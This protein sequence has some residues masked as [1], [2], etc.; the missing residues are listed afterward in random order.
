MS[1][2]RKKLPGIKIGLVFIL[3]LVIQLVLPFS[4]LIPSISD[5]VQGLLSISIS[6]SVVNYHTIQIKWNPLKDCNLYSLKRATSTA[7]PW[8]DLGAYSTTTRTDTVPTPSTLYYYKVY[9]FWDDGSTFLSANAESNVVWI[10]SF[11]A[12]VIMSITPAYNS[13]AVGWYD[14]WDAHGYIVQ[15]AVASSGYWY[16]LNP[17]TGLTATIYG[18]QTG[19]NYD[20]RIRAYHDSD[21]R[22]Y[23]AWSSIRTGKPMPAKP[24]GMSATSINYN[25]L[26]LSWQSVAGATSY[27]LS[28]ATS[29]TGN[30][31]SIGGIIT[32]TAYTDANLT[33]GMTYYYWVTAW[34]EVGGASYGSESSDAFSGTPIPG[35]PQNL[36]VASAGYNSLRLDWSSVDGAAGYNVRRTLNPKLGPWTELPLVIVK[37]YCVDTGLLTGTQYFYEVRAYVNQLKDI[38]VYGNWSS[39]AYATPV[40]ATPTGLSAVAY[41]TQPYSIYLAWSSVSGA[42]GYLIERSE[43]SAGPWA[44]LADVTILKYDDRAIKLDVLYYYRIIA[45]TMVNKVQYYSSPSK[46][47]SAKVVSPSPTP[48]P[49]ITPLPDPSTTPVPDP[50]TT[51]IPDPS[52]TPIPEPSTTTASPSPSPSPTPNPSGVTPAASET[53]QAPSDTDPTATTNGTTQGQTSSD[54]SGETSSN[55]ETTSTTRASASETTLASQSSSGTPDSSFTTS[56]S[57]PDDQNTEGKG[58]SSTIWL[59]IIL[60]VIAG[61]GVGSGFGLLFAGRKK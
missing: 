1:R 59:I 54:T 57:I 25:A 18:L 53:T 28:R 55:S 29:L 14:L 8:T 32:N 21:K 13:L 7:G 60:A 41:S 12:P 37:N 11:P 31:W 4:S 43:S 20:V 49:S 61:L 15:Y 33:C 10:T 30:R 16:E 35:T 52:T 51:P 5:S 56:T 2:R 39:Y 58:N 42:S 3:I 46:Y 22:Y 6:A 40:L 17:V 24:T 48:E 26:H 36:V 50:S 47:V 45:Y 44:K 23:S 38:K 27:R 9:G 19:T 34:R